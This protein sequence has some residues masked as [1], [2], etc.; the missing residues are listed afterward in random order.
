MARRS[1]DG[2]GVLVL[3]GLSDTFFHCSPFGN[4]QKTRLLSWEET[5]YMYLNK[6]YAKAKNMGCLES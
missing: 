2:S 1:A 6:E 3:L 5:N 4:I